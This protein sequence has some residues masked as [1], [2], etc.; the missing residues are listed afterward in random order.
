MFRSRQ[1]PGWCGI[2]SGGANEKVFTETKPN[3]Q[4]VADDIEENFETYLEG[5]SKMSDD[6]LQETTPEML[7]FATDLAVRIGREITSLLQRS[8]VSINVRCHCKKR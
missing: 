8:T 1:G 5:M 2:I 6:G 7:K 4:E 3:E